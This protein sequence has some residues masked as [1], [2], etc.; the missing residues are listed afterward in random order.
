[1]FAHSFTKFDGADGIPRL[2][3]AWRLESYAIDGKDRTAAVP[4]ISEF[5]ASK[6]AL[7]YAS[8][9]CFPNE[10]AEFRLGVVSEGSSE[11]EQKIFR[12]P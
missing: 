6:S 3:A 8:G 5:L 12:V 4:E 7:N 11:S 2:K 10:S 1:M 9:R